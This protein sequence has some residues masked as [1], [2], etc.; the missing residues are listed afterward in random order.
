MQRLLQTLRDIRYSLWFIPAVMVASGVG[1]A[2]LA[3]DTDARIGEEALSKWPLLFGASADGA[4]A[5]WPSRE[6]FGTD[7]ALPNE[8]YGGCRKHVVQLRCAVLFFDHMTNAKSDD[9]ARTGKERQTVELSKLPSSLGNSPVSQTPKDVQPGDAAARDVTERKVN[10]DNPAE[11]Q[12]AL[13]D[14]ASEL[15]FPASDPI[16]VPT[17][18]QIIKET[19]ISA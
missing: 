7:F 3:I 2:M 10:S 14:E 19:R 4:R 11:R 8:I 6:I 18:D 15:S 1:L 12:E 13:L 5:T 16:A 17:M 9:D